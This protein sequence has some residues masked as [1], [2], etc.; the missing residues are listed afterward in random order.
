MQRSVRLIVVVA[1]VRAEHGRGMA[2]V[3]DQDAVE[4]LAADAAAAALGDRVGSRG[5]TGVLSTLRGP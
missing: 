4:E 5:R 1:L 3:E 2:L